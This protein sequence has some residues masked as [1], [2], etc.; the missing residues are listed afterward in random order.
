MNPNKNPGFQLIFKK[1]FYLSL[2]VLLNTQSGL[3]QV[4]VLVA[5]HSETGYTEQMA[6]AVAEG[7]REIEGVVVYLKSVENVEMDLLLSSDAIIVGS[8]VYNANVT[9]QV[10]EFI[11]S[12]PFDGNLG[13]GR[14]CASEHTEKHAYIRDDHRGRGRLDAAFR[15]QCGDG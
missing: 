4:Q 9:P 7:A 13:R 14:D 8:P 3:G 10:S 6:E 1:L 15:R 5:Y 12:W 2:F 11:A